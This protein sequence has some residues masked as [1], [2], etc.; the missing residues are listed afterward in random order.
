LKKYASQSGKQFS[1]IG[2]RKQEKRYC[3][4]WNAETSPVQTF[5]HVAEE[6]ESLRGAVG[7]WDRQAVGS[8]GAQKIILQQ[9]GV[10]C[11]EKFNLEEI[12]SPL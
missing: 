3:M 9:Y 10:F 1:R 6:S 11:S 8:V 12:K 7:F 5:L 4:Y 2:E